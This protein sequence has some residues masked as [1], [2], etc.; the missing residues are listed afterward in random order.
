MSI[1][2]RNNF[3][4]DRSDTFRIARI[5]ND[6]GNN[7]FNLF[8]N[9]FNLNYNNFD[10][11]NNFLGGNNIKGSLMFLE[12][13]NKSIN[14]NLSQ[15]V[16]DLVNCFI[17][18]SPAQEPLTCPKCNNFG[19]KKC[20]EAYFGNSMT[21]PCPLCKQG[22]S[23]NE[24]KQNAVIKEIEDILNKDDTKKNKY[25]E[26]SQLIMRK[27]QSCESQSSDIN[28]MLDRLFKCQDTLR[29]YKEQYDFFL[30][31]MKQI[32]ENIFNEYNQKIEILVN[33]LLAFNKMTDSTI[34]KYNDIKSSL[35][36]NNNIKSLINEILSL[37]RKQF[38]KNHHNDNDND[39][40]K[41][42]E[43][44][45]K[46][47]IKIVPSI[48]LYHVKDIYY[49]SDVFKTNKNEVFTGN[50]FRIGDYELSYI[51]DPNEICG[52]CKL[53]FTLKDDAKKMCFLITQVLLYNNKE[54]LIPMKL[55]K[56][57]NKTYAYECKILSDE[58][59][60]LIDNPNIKFYLK[61]EAIIFAV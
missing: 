34:K 46:T 1:Y 47:S 28:N 10:N 11:Q 30:V 57:D 41:D 55:V 8:N 33:S 5:M 37:E 49:Y 58:I 43:D 2:D 14:Q 51:F 22:I 9:N 19:C 40:N 45:F 52:F 50:H 26:L 18:L 12:D 20:L 35:N 23:L 56:E 53:N 42:V 21:K 16:F 31:Q 29:K 48:N 3:R 15:S 27:K 38:N 24:L 32:I 4:M 13:L 61:T 39:N 54:V 6:F 17:C 59:S 25:D 7:N 36:N 60:E 44:F